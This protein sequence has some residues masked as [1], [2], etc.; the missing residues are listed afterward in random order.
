MSTI[1]EDEW[2]G[3]TLK[4]HPKYVRADVHRSFIYAKILDDN[5]CLMKMVINGDPHIVCIPQKLINW[6]LKNVIG[7]FV[8]YLGSKAKNLPE[9]Y[10][11]LIEEKEE[12]YSALMD[13]ISQLKTTSND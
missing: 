7:V 12:Y 5:R 11:K 2:M 9:E 13:K 1:E 10:L 3:V 4:R 8:K 6:A